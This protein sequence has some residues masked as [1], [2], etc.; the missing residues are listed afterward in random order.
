MVWLGLA[1]LLLGAI[2]A[3][4]AGLTLGLGFPA[5]R[6]TLPLMLGAGLLIAGLLS[7]IRRR[8]VRAGLL[9]ALIGLAL[10]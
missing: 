9:A 2:P 7:L 6:L 10:A 1:A 8:P 3:R 4:V 5:D